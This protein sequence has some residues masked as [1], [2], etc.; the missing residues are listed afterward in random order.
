MIWVVG[1]GKEGTSSSESRR[2]MHA[3]VSFDH[4]IAHIQVRASCCLTRHL[5]FK[6]TSGHGRRWCY[7]G[8]D[9]W[10]VLTARPAILRAGTASLCQT[11]IKGAPASCG[12][13]L[14][15]KQWHH[16]GWAQGLALPQDGG[17]CEARRGLHFLIV[18]KS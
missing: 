7:S 2:G 9:T 14:K 11:S 12:V 13:Y 17:L 4:K 6:S 1:T 10:T 15:D 5:G 18:G 8:H 16:L 3:N